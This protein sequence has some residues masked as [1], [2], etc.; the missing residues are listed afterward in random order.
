[1]PLPSFVPVIGSGFDADAA[2]QYQWAGFNQRQDEANMRRAQIADEAANNWFT[3]L[4]SMQ[5]QENERR[6]RLDQAQQESDRRNAIVSGQIEYAKQQ[7]KEG[8]RRFDI[9]QKLAEKEF[10][11]KK[12]A[13]EEQQKKQLKLVS[14]FAT[15]F[16]PE[17]QDSAQKIEEAQAEHAKAEREL[18]TKKSEIESDPAF[19][20]GK[21]HYDPRSQEFVRNE[22]VRGQPVALEPKQ[23]EF[24]Q[25]ANKELSG[26]G[27]D[28]LTAKAALDFRMKDFIEKQK[29]ANQYSLVP[30]K[31]DGKWVLYSPDLDIT[32]GQ[33][34]KNA[35]KEAA[36]Q[37]FPTSGA[38]AG[39]SNPA[40]PAPTRTA[41]D[42]TGWNRG[43][44]LGK[45]IGLSAGTG[46]AV[47]FIPEL[48]Q[49]N[50]IAPLPTTGVT[51]VWRRGPDGKLVLVQ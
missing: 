32:F 12:N 44:D 2:Q 10:E 50:A 26:L 37:E 21:A 16:V 20:Q 33:E 14:N 3:R 25:S 35:K 23:L 48:A 41:T 28:F 17:F 7:D 36:F 24:L 22:I 8:A 30:K 29:Q 38:W 43:V 47:P 42:N 40:A 1:M 5:Q 15:N 13:T 31:A 11:F 34:V 45:L 39:F 46:G 49:R 9:Q 4:A 19:P 27:A 6:D 51:K 18:L